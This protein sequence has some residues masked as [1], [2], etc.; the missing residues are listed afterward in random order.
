MGTKRKGEDMQQR[1]QGQK[2]NLTAASRTY[3]L[4]LYATLLPD[5]AVLAEVILH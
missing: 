4:Y 5:M 2:T 3:S 1:S